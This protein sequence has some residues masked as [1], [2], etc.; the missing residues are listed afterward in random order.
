MTRVIETKSG[1]YKMKFRPEPMGRLSRYDYRWGRLPM[2]GDPHGVLW[3]G[4]VHEA[5]WDDQ[6]C[7]IYNESIRRGLWFWK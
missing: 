7:A 1:P 4:Y 5:D 6:T 2:V 3:P